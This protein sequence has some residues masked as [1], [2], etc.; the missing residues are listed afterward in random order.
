MPLKSIRNKDKKKEVGIKT[1]KKKLKGIQSIGSNIQIIGIPNREN[2]ENGEKKMIILNGDQILKMSGKWCPRNE[3]IKIYLEKWAPLA[4]PACDC[5]V[6][7][8]GD[9][10]SLPFLQ[11]II[12]TTQSPC[13]LFC[14]TLV[15]SHDSA[16]SFVDGREGLL[17]KSKHN[18]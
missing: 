11:A 17:F 6:K 3:L 7:G 10:R 18:T 9:W 4:S 8:G 13:V 5:K 14:M 16:L 15:H 1:K 2:K 12:Q